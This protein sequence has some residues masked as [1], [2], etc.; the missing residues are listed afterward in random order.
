MWKKWF[1]KQK[2]TAA[3]SEMCSIDYERLPKHIAIIMDGNGRWAQRRGM[4]RT[5]GHRAGVESLREIV[6]LSS[7]IGL[8]ALTAYAF[9]TENWK[10]PQ[11]EVDLLMRLFSDYLDSEIE[12]L[13]S[14]N[15]KIRFIGNLQ[16]L[17]PFLQEKIIM[18]QERTGQN[19]GLS[20]NLAVNYGGRAELVR[21]VQQIATEAVAGTLPVNQISEQTISTHLY[22]PELAEVDL[23]IRPSGD[24]RISNFLLWQCAYAE[25]WFTPIHWPDFKPEHLLAAIRDF[26]KRERRFGGLKK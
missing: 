2:T 5:F 18:A 20:F 7:D 15:V 21:A 25:F 3:T 1:K 4:P 9:S 24:Y 12:E 19:G 16:G 22:Q 8:S 17:S 14:K 26:Q 23:L 13:H 11:E 6:R 10:R